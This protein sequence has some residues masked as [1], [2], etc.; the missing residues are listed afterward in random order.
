MSEP[1][2]DLRR[3]WGAIRRR[4]ALMTTLGL[5]GICGGVA[6]G[7][8]KPVL[9]GAVSMV[10]LPP[11]A[12]TGAGTPLR[13][14]GTQVAIATSEPVLDEA[15]QSV[16][17]PI[18]ARQLKPNVTVTALSQDVL[19]IRVKAADAGKAKRLANAIASDYIHYVTTT[20]TGLSALSAQAAQ[21][22]QQLSALQSQI[23]AATARLSSE[24]ASSTSGQQSSALLE[25]LNRELTTTSQELSTVNSQI[26]QAGLSGQVDAGAIRILQRA[27]VATSS[28]NLRLPLFGVIGLVAGLFL[29]AVIAISEGQRDR[30]LRRR[31]DL[32]AA[33]GVPV[34]ASVEAERCR[35]A[36]D[37]LKL[38]ERY[39]P[40]VVDVWALRRLLRQ[41]PA[42]E[43]RPHGSVRIMSFADDLAALA[44]GPQVATFAASVGIRTAV[45][46]DEDPVV[47]HLRA[48]CRSAHPSHRPAQ[49]LALDGEGSDPDENVDLAIYVTAVQRIQPQLDG[50]ARQTTL[51]AV[52]SGFATVDDLARLALAAVD[53]GHPIEG[54][55]VANPDPDDSTTGGASDATT[56]R[57]LP[58]AAASSRTR[59]TLT[60]R[61]RP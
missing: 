1:A 58:Q 8:L 26:A 27:T 28:S 30:R 43:G 22:T 16:S 57:R 6:Y 9:P 49:L 50:P 35:T 41:L 25:Q 56:L 55:V 51:L 40:S 44:I 39:R 24:G 60:A 13:D 10:L 5:I 34:L 18:G 7:V 4:R 33:L 38:L 36:D 15:G 42:E 53:S 54:I 20:G 21:L 23:S 11:P 14:T 52:S 45:L 46:P 3:A 37:W 47:V 32:V 29:G 61:T 17:P 2:L 31:D 59:A 19:S 12:T 48:A